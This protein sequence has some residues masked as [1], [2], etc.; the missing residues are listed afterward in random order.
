[1]RHGDTDRTVCPY[2]DNMSLCTPLCRAWQEPSGDR[3]G[4]CMRL[5]SEIDGA[6]FLYE[7]TQQLE[8]L[9]KK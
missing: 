1:M 2:R 4:Y 5:E 3:A 9:C 6:A 8:R 7:I